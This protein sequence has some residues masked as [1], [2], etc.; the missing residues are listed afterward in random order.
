MV[1]RDDQW[2]EVTRRIIGQAFAILQRQLPRWRAVADACDM[3][4]KKFNLRSPG[5]YFTLSRD[6]TK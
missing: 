1:L 3:L 5:G 2:T 4:G 6:F